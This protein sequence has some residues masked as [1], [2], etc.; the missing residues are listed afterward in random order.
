MNAI[1]LFYT[2]YFSKIERN[3]CHIV[4]VL[5]SFNLSIFISI[6][7]ISSICKDPKVRKKKQGKKM[8][9]KIRNKMNSMDKLF[10]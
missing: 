1:I 3:G 6:L 7:S 4:H 9:K 10:V 8:I 2:T 5:G